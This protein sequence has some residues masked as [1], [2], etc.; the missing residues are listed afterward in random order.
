MPCYSL[1]LF[2]DYFGA[3]AKT[4][5][6]IPASN[7]VIYVKLGRA[8]IQSNK[9]SASLP[10]NAALFTPEPL[11]IYSSSQGAEL[12]RYEL[13]K[14][15]ETKNCLTSE[16]V[17]KELIHDAELELDA[18]ENYLMRCDR[19]DLPAGGIAYTH[20]H[21]GPGTRYLLEGDF[22]V[23]TNGNV[24]NLSPGEA[25]FEAGPEPV[26]AY[27]PHDRV[28]QFLRVMILPRELK[29]KSSIAY[30]KPEDTT[31]PK[32]QSYTIFVDEFITI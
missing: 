1:R 24:F 3:E 2:R 17:T 29:G 5:E 7:R 27:A 22:N 15:D 26:L 32:K 21:Q 31:K 10:S 13:V 23:E 25:W 20:T 30:V 18:G 8:S 6:M 28:G 16:K 4:E 9:I 12:L 14:T 19:V 11:R